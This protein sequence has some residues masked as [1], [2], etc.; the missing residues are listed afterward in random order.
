MRAS[1]SSVKEVVANKIEQDAMAEKPKIIYNKENTT[2]QSN[3]RTWP[4][5]EVADSMQAS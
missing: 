1:Q 4:Y 2:K 3:K 5:L